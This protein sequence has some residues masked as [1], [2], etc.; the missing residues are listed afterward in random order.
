MLVVG[1]KGSSQ[2]LVLST[3]LLQGTPVG[4]IAGH[5]YTELRADPRV[6]L[7]VPIAMGDNVGGAR[8][9]G[10]DEHFFDLRPSQQEPPAFQLAAGQSLWR[11]LRGRAGQPCSG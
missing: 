5:I 2:Q 1:A 11:R 3:L 9:V 6:A 4:N 8:I 7:A 10:T